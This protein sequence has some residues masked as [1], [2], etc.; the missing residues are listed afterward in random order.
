MKE[1]GECIEGF[2]C[3]N[4]ATEL[5]HNDCGYLACFQVHLHVNDVDLTIQKKS[6]EKCKQNECIL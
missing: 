6:V 3:T 5:R 4:M 2:L 1:A